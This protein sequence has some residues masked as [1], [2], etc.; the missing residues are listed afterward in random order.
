MTRPHGAAAL[1]QDRPP[2]TSAST[3]RPSDSAD[4]DAEQLWHLHLKHR[5][6]FP[7]LWQLF[8]SDL[9]SLKAIFRFFAAHMDIL[10]RS[11]P[12]GGRG[13]RELLDLLRSRVAYRLDRSTQQLHVTAEMNVRE[14][15]D[16]QLDALDTLGPLVGPAFDAF[17]AGAL[18]MHSSLEFLAPA[19]T[20][21]DLPEPFGARYEP[22][23]ALFFT[24][25]EFAF[26]AIQQGFD[27]DDRWLR[28]LPH[29]IRAQHVFVW[30]Y[31]ETDENGNPPPSFGFDS[32]DMVFGSSHRGVS[33]E[34]VQSIPLALGA[35]IEQLD[36]LA[37][38][39]ALR[40]FPSGMKGARRSIRRASS[41]IVSHY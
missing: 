33:L 40:A 21:P 16:A 5:G 12:D 22:D 20:E 4:A 29:L 28:T 39:A 23:G 13:L 8:G 10:T 2:L 25:A 14:L 7:A 32:Y 9:D 6:R 3:P 30:A 38:E 27:R 11:T 41:T 19:R 36:G 37:T 34:R 17:S 31:G 1:L 15:S 35:T 26:V 18:A 24:W